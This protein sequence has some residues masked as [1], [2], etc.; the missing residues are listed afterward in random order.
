MWPWSRR[1]AEAQRQLAEAEERNRNAERLAQQS[2]KI[3]AQL[4][5]EVRK[6]GFT[7][8]LQHAMGGR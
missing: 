1:V 2:R 6:N 7:E 4:R 5:H 8:L 3:S